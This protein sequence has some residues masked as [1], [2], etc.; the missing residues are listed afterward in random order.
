MHETVP[1]YR[2]ENHPREHLA[3]PAVCLSSK[4][5]K[6]NLNLVKHGKCTKTSLF[7][8]SL[9]CEGSHGTELRVH[10]SFPL[11]PPFLPETGT[12]YREYQHP[13]CEREME[14]TVRD[15]RAES[16]EEAGT[17][18]ALWACFSTLHCLLLDIFHAAIPG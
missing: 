13:Y 18:L 10:L 6:Q 17:L 9:A 1:F 5:Y 7:S 2:L 4:H 15:G 11:L 14:A 12:R 16:W 3:D 8:D